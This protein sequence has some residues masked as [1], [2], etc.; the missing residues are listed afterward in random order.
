[1][2]LAATN[3]EA[4]TTIMALARGEMAYSALAA[5]VERH[6]DEKVKGKR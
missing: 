2:R 4:Y 5:W 6:S 3:D 1:M